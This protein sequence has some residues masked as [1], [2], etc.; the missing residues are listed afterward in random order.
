MLN[1]VGISAYFHDA[2]CCLL[3]DG[4]LVAAAQEERF[5]RRKHDP[6]L[7]R[8]AFR[9]CL[10]RAGLTI[11]DVD[12]LGYYE[13]PQR[14]LERQIWQ[15]LPNLTSTLAARIAQKARQPLQD[16]ADLLGYDGRVEVVDH[17]AA[18]AASCFFFSGFRR[19]AVMTVDGVGEWATTTYGVGCGTELDVIEEVRFP[20]SLGLLYSAITSY[21]GFAVN[22]GEYKVMGL[23]PYG[24][25]R[26]LDQ[27]RQLLRIDEGG[28]Y[29]LNLE[30]FDFNR[31]DQ[32]YADVLPA[33]FGQPPRLADAEI[34]QAHRDIARSVQTVLEEVLLAKARWL[35][36]RTGEQDLCMAGGVALNCVANSRILREGPFRRLFVQPAAGDAG[37]SLGAAA[38]AHIRLTGERPAQPMRHAALGPAFAPEAIGALL[39]SA[40]I[41]ATDYRGREDDLLDATVDRLIR[42]EV[43]GWFHGRME[44]GPRALG[45]R[46]ILGD[47]RDPTMRDRINALVKMR[48]SF[49]PFAPAVLESSAGAHFE[50][51]HPSPFMLET[52]QVRSPM[53]LPAVTHVDNSARVQTVSPE[54][55][56]RFARLLER[57]G[58]ATGCPMLLN[59]SF[60]MR[61]EPIVC[62]PVDALLSFS[63]SNLDALVLE[64]FFIDRRHLPETWDVVV[65]SH[66]PL[67]SAVTDR[68]YT[69][70]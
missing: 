65:R 29:R 7:P 49:R 10:E 11:A 31:T 67:P 23:A 63:R 51:D 17:H 43:V 6:S 62:S 35:H 27:V 2:A 48:E 12:C 8:T 34:H 45:H 15:S 58:R 25:P 59:T 40:A 56:R 37:G 47:P 54:T 18:H 19:A 60:N 66:T 4:V 39:A 32:M 16:I 3:Q 24:A 9:Y 33:L 46:S 26:F 61:D 52:A 50:L 57:F 53:P 5:S 21:L 38:L 30:F 42:G 41:P 69:L 55:N 70:M 36:E 64:D 14:K 68:I 20:D 22:D 1:I 44:F 13:D 28:Q